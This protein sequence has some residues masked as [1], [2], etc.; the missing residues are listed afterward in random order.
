MPGKGK[1]IGAVDAFVSE[2]V[3]RFAATSASAT[4]ENPL[5]LGNV[6]FWIGTGPWRGVL[7]YS[8][9]SYAWDKDSVQADLSSYLAD[10][11]D[12]LKEYLH[13]V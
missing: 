6:E 12:A 3:L 1:V 9:P 7:V 4:D 13:I 10:K 5:I 11:T 8:I 2:Q